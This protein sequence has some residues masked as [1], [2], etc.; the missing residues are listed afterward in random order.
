[1]SAQ[2]R[3]RPLRENGCVRAS[4]YRKGSRCGRALTPAHGSAQ[5]DSKV[6]VTAPTLTLP[7]RGRELS[8]GPAKKQPAL[9]FLQCFR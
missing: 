5:D 3:N 8:C 7:L 2:L 4:F 9:Q 1:M 6:L